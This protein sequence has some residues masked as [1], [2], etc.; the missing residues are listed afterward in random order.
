[1][2]QTEFSAIALSGFTVAFFHVAMPTHWL[3]FVLTAR[4]QRWSRAKALAITALAA[5][6][7]VVFTALLG[8]LVTVFG[9]ALH[10]RTAAWFPRV[11]GSVLV[12]FGLLHLYR[13]VLGHVHGH[14]RVIGEDP[15]V[16][17]AHGAFGH[18][19][20]IER[21]DAT[22][23]PDHVAITSLLA[24]LTFSP[25]EA[26]VP[27]YISGLHYGWFGFWLLTAI[28]SIA[29]L[30][31][32]VALTWLTLVG[33]RQIAL[34]QLERYELGVMGILLCAVG[35]LIIIFNP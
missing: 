1:M 20:E 8:L 12:L 19:L 13:Q 17:A 23:V 7:H 5:S 34:R 11:G 3:P 31:G 22:H 4:A 6:G 26:F 2:N 15:R 21:H 32:M 10:E 25:C 16:H 30:T 35:V 29:T 9:F 24:L 33:I 28:L 18:E 27:F 14:S